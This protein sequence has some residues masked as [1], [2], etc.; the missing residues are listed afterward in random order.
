MAGKNKIE[1]KVEDVERT[2]LAKGIARI[3]QAAMK[4][5]Q[6]SEGDM[7]EIVGNKKTVARAHQANPE[8]AGKNVI[9]IDAYTRRNAG[10]KVGGH[11]NICRADVLEAEKIFIAPSGMQLTVD[12]LL[13]KFLRNNLLDKPLMKESIVVVM[14]LAHPVLFVVVHTEPDGSVIFTE[15]T[16]LRVFSKLSKIS[17]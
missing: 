4:I 9:R 17:E 12:D 1:L 14:M 15:K 7:I 2:D 10:A 13:L 5:L 3:D 11:V 6:I 16:E 8:D